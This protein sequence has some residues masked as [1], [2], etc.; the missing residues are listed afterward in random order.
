[1]VAYD[2]GGGRQAPL[3]GKERL[4]F[5]FVDGDHSYDGLRVDYEGFSP[6]IAKGGIIALHDS[7]PTD[8]CPA[9]AGSVR[10]TRDVILKD[11]GVERIEVVDSLTILR[12][13]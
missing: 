13:R 10:F 11:P 8:H 5:V 9:D 3:R 2:G 6:L 7:M 4:D 1:M 12:K